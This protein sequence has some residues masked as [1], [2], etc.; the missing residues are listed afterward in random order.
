MERLERVVEAGGCLLKVDQLGAREAGVAKGF[1]LT[2]DVGRLLLEVDPEAGRIRSIAIEGVDEIPSGAEVVSEED[3]WW[4]L[5]GYP[6]ARVVAGEIGAQGLRLQFRADHENPRVVV[7]Q[8]SGSEVEVT[9]EP[10]GGS[11]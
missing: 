6:L 10:T 5:L 8:P 4:R 11:A 3:P 7:L 1:L 2:F 9:L